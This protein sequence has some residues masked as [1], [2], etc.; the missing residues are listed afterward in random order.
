MS[1]LKVENICKSFG[2]LKVLKNNS[3]EVEKGEVVCIIGPSGAGKSTL[4]RTINQ[5]ETISS[6]KIWVND[7]L[8]VDR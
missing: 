2:N 7:T 3:L 1:I 8:L 5:L 4:L 6:G